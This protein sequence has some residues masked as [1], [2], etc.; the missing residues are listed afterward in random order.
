L[1]I[2][3]DLRFPS[4][5]QALRFGAAN[6]YDAAGSHSEGTVAGLADVILVPSAFTPKTGEPHWEVLL[7][8]RAIET[9]CY[10]I[11]AAQSGKGIIV[12]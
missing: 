11:A 12:I 8:A 5:F 9:Q 2:C 7:R 4:L 6:G 3:F 1:T 10:I